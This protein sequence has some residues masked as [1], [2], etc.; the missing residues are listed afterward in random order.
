MKLKKAIGFSTKENKEIEIEF[1]LN[2]KQILK[3]VNKFF[4]TMSYSDREKWISKNTCPMGSGGDMG[5]AKSMFQS[6]Q[7]RR[8]R[9]LV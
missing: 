7:E 6:A 5:V 3:I 1:D 9:G 2:K 8:C 4:D